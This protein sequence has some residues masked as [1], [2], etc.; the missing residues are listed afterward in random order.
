MAATEAE[1]KAILTRLAGDGPVGAV[2]F[3][4]LDILTTADRQGIAPTAVAPEDPVRF[5]AVATRACLRDERSSMVLGVG[6]FADAM[7]ARQPD[8]D[9]S[10]LL[11]LHRDGYEVVRRAAL[12]AIELAQ[13]GGKRAARRR[14]RR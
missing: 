12:A 13:G 11:T 5:L 3:R 14:A 9:A 8:A 4:A 7:M 10:T 6:E 2:A 1:T